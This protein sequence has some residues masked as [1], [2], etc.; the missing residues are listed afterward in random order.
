MFIKTTCNKR[1]NSELG[2]EML[3]VCG[4]FFAV[5]GRA[6]DRVVT[7]CRA[8]VA[9]AR[10]TDMLLFFGLGLVPAAVVEGLHLL[11]DPMGANLRDVLHVVSDSA[12]QLLSYT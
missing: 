12:L 10:H 5:Q 3:C 8:I 6:R 1:L 4:V 9:D 11:W 7:L 2:A